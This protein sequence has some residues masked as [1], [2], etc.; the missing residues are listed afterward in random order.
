MLTLEPF[1]RPPP[2][3]GRLRNDR[4]RFPGA[5]VPF[6]KCPPQA[7][8]ECETCSPMENPADSARCRGWLLVFLF[9]RRA[10]AAI[11]TAREYK[12]VLDDRTEAR[13]ARFLLL[14][15][16]TSPRPDRKSRLR[17]RDRE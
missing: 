9:V 4:S 1:C 3:N 2:R 6:C 7:R 11:E 14:F 15:L 5:A 13:L 10:S 8:I 12:D 16:R 17:L